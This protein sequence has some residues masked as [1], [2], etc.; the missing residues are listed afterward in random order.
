MDAKAHRAKIDE[1]GPDNTKLAHAIG[2]N[3]SDEDLLFLKQIGLRWVRLHYRD[4]DADV[5]KLRGIQERF[6]Q[7]GLQIYS[8]GHPAYR[9]A[10]IQLGQPGRD[11]DIELFCTFNQ[12]YKNIMDN[13]FGPLAFKQQRRRQSNKF[14]V[15]PVINLMQQSFIAAIIFPY[16]KLVFYHFWLP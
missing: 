14:V 2:A 16:P 8:V 5:D 12:P 6:A 4:W 9:S 10:K 7:Y 1:Y 3:A 11:E 15:V 13:I